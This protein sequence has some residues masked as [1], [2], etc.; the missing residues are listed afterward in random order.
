VPAGTSVDLV[1]G[2]G[3]V[4]LVSARLA[5][6]FAAGLA[7]LVAITAVA[8]GL[9]IGRDALVRATAGGLVAG[10]VAAGL[11]G[12][13]GLGI[14]LVTLPAIAAV[15]AAGAALGGLA[16]GTAVAGLGRAGLAMAAVGGLALLSPSGLLRLTGILL[17]APALAVA[18][19]SPAGTS[20]PAR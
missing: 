12:W 15:T 1:G 7:L 11:V 6:R 14:D 16:A 2:D 8:L 9:A 5:R 17:A 3:A 19:V 18:L 13:L 20:T 4:V 10:A